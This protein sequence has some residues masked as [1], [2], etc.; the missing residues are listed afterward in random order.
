[1]GRRPVDADLTRTPFGPD[2]IGLQ[3]AAG[4]DIGHQ[5]LFVFM[6]TGPFHQDRIE[7]DGADV[8]QVGPGHLGPVDFT[9]E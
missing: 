3:T 1:M 6:E 7:G 4:G 2:D 8:V 9:L 5:H